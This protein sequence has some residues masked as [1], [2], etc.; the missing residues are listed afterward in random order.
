MLQALR[1]NPNRRKVAATQFVPAPT[2]G[3]V[4]TNNIA[5]GK[6]GTAN[7]LENF[8]PKP[9]T[10]ELRGGW[11]QHSDTTETVPVNTLMAWHGPSSSKLFGVSN[12]TIYD[13]TSSTASATSITTLT[14]SKCKYVNFTTS[15]GH[16]LFVVNGADTAKHYNGSAWA[17]P[18]ITGETSDS[19]SNVNVYKQRLFFI[20][21]NSLQFA[22]LP[23]QS[24]AGAATTYELGDLFTMGGHLVAMGT[25]SID[26]GVGPDDHAV[27]ITSN[28]QVALFQGSNPS[29]A[30]DW[31]LVGVFTMARPLG[32]RCMLQV[33][34]DLYINTEIGV[35]PLSQ[36]LKVDSAALAS[37]VVTRNIAP[38]INLAASRYK[39][40]FGW[41]IIGY[42]KGTMAIINVPISEGVKQ[43]QFVM[44][45]QTGAWCKF[46]NQN[47]ACWEVM[48]G[49]LYFGG[50]DGKVYQADSAASDGGASISG[51]MQTAYDPFGNAAQLKA[52]KQIRPIIY[53]QGSVAPQVGLNVD[54]VSSNPTGTISQASSNNAQWGTMVWGS[55]TWAGGRTLSAKWR[56][57]TDKPGYVAAVR[58]RVLASGAGDPVL[59]QVNGFQV[60][61]ENGGI[62]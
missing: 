9:D 44:N 54:F 49:D 34:G 14:S 1:A 50:N 2:L 55:F 43:E 57:L 58:M 48:D 51:D 29:D 56:A 16:F 13:V 35:L 5:L 15:G 27:F 17:T 52:W 42:P 7:I 4:A 25:L 11:A 10:V 47:A 28:G 30:N 41:Q 38:E 3:W 45:S 19:F 37:V 18:S 36:A 60:A 22:Y 32:D 23:V 40:N 46:T 33:G 20:V 6:P 61:Y 26:G 24:I 8:F 12:D 62:M 39:S 59:L 31:S 21:K 53:A